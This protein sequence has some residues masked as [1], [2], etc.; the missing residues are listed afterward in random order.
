MGPCTP[1]SDHSPLVTVPVSSNRLITLRSEEV[2]AAWKE[3]CGLEIVA[4]WLESF[5]RSDPG[6]SVACQDT[7]EP[8]FHLS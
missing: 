3:R 1:T 5:T 7:L 6:T 8:T 4:L 2:W